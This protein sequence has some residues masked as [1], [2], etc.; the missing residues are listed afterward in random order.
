ME[1]VTTNG[2]TIREVTGWDEIGFVADDDEVVV[3]FGGDFS[4][5]ATWLDAR[6]AVQTLGTLTTDQLVRLGSRQL[7]AKEEPDTQVVTV[8]VDGSHLVRYRDGV[9]LRKATP[10]EAERSAR[11]AEEDGGRGLFCVELP[12]ERA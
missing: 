11:E 5:Y 8:Y 3:H 6:G 12:E 4:P 10:D 2:A 1:K 9:V 7:D